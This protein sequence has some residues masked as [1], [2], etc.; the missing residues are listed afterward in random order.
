MKKTAKYKEGIR[1]GDRQRLS[2][3]ALRDPL[4]STDAMHKIRCIHCEREYPAADIMWIEEVQLWCCPHENCGG[5][6]VGCDLWE[7]E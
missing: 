7:C 1:F 5:C 4:G 3:Q 6:G 2:E